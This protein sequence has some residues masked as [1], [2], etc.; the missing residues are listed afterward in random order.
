MT[1]TIENADRIARITLAVCVI[2]FYSLELITGPFALALF[3]LASIAILSF[4]A[5]VAYKWM[6]T[7]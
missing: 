4:L 3:I 6:T 7:D 2:L 1:Q 5:K